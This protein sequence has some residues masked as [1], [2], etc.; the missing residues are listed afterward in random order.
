MTEPSADAPHT[1]G[2]DGTDGTEATDD[3]VRAPLSRLAV[4]SLVASVLSPLTYTLTAYAGIA[5]GIVA[6]R[7]IH[8]LGQRGSRLAI[9]GIVVG[10]VMIV[11]LSITL[12][13]INHHIAAN[14]DSHAYK[15]KDYQHFCVDKRGPLMSR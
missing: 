1:D 12:V 14:C 3:A 7:R 10:I 5:L 4:A 2:T 9:S 6:L 15:G 11:L 8:R 13:L